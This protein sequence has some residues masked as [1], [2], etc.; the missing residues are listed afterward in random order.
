M[1]LYCLCFDHIIQIQCTVVLTRS[2]K[3]MLYNISHPLCHALTFFLSTGFL[4]DITSSYN[5]TF[6]FSG[7]SIAIC[8]CILSLVPVFAPMRT[9]VPVEIK[10]TSNEIAEIKRRPSFFEKYVQRHF[11][12][13]YQRPAEV[14]EHLL[15]VDK[16]TAVWNFQPSTESVDELKGQLD[17]SVICCL[18][19]IIRA[20][21][22][23]S[24]DWRV[25]VSLIIY[26]GRGWIPVSISLKPQKSSKKLLNSKKP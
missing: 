24:R 10:M 7:A 12:A 15:V 22:G 18:A 4:S 14:V 5:E 16:I 19:K 26:G 3:K 1:R 23:F 8:A 17:E 13:S 2:T 6:Y 20:T 9:S 21:V 11:S 25:F